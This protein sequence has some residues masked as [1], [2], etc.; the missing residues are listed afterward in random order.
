M[1]TFTV[2]RR[3]LRTEVVVVDA[4]T[5]EEA[6]AAAKQE[7]AWRSFSTEVSHDTFRWPNEPAAV[8]DITSGARVA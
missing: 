8:F 1:A 7:G 6:V 5:E 4:D 3:T 2:G